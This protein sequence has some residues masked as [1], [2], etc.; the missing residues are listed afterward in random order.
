MVNKFDKKILIGFIILFVNYFVLK[1]I[2][3]TSIDI[4][5]YEG[6]KDQYSLK[7]V[8]Y[9]VIS[10]TSYLIILSSIRDKNNHT[11]QGYIINGIYWSFITLLIIFLSNFII[12]EI[13]I[14]KIFLLS[15]DCEIIPSLKPWYIF[16]IGVILCTI[17]PLWI[18]ILGIFRGEKY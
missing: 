5:F 9:F 4:V 13:F 7:D 15:E 3:N 10:I 8:L 6:T 18:W 14:K 11:I 1:L 17:K 2:D 16:S 12:D